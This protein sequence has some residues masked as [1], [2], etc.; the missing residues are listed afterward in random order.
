MVHDITV[1]I[2]YKITLPLPVLT[3]NSVVIIA[4]VD[5]LGTIAQ[6]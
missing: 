3:W 6:M 2:I 5:M 4:L 1:Q